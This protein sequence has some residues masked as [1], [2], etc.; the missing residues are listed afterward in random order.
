MRGWMG[1]PAGRGR[2][3]APLDVMGLAQ[4]APAT[5]P[6]SDE[7]LQAMGSRRVKPF[8]GSDRCPPRI[9]PIPAAPARNVRPWR[10]LYNR[11]PLLSTP[12]PSTPEFCSQETD[13]LLRREVW[14]LFLAFFQH[15]LDQSRTR[16]VH[17]G[18]SIRFRRDNKAIC[19]SSAS[20]G[21]HQHHH[22]SPSPPPP[23]T[24]RHHQP[25]LSYGASICVRCS[26]ASSRARTCGTTS[27]T[28][29]A[30]SSLSTSAP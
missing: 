11:P 8:L 12:A 1:H 25:W 23:A 5:D 29:A 16:I 13:L 30:P 7:H 24:T 9:K 14:P 15:G 19:N 20:C 28:C 26:G 3:S 17:S 4:G 10:C 18:P 27:T 22:I 21:R 6:R 2:E